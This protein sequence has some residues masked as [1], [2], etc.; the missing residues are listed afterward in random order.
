LSLYYYKD[1]CKVNSIGDFDTDQSITVS[2]NNGHFS[3]EIY[4]VNLVFTITNQDEDSLVVYEASSYSSS[5]SICQYEGKDIALNAEFE[6][7]GTK[8]EGGTYVYDKE[9]IVVDR[10]VE[11][12]KNVNF[13]IKCQSKSD[14]DSH[15]SVCPKNVKITAGSC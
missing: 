4:G 8:N 13:Y 6:I 9:N 15:S 12:K 7:H 3:A 11:Q 10:G 2:P 1:D 14:T 5:K